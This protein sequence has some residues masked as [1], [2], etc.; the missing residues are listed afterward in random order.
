[1]SALRA[2]TRNTSGSKEFVETLLS[3]RGTIEAL[4]SLSLL[5]RGDA[6]RKVLRH[7]PT[8]LDQL[9]LAVTTNDFHL[10]HELARSGINVDSDIAEDLPPIYAAILLGRL[11]MIVALVREGAEVNRETRNG[12]TPLILAALVED[13][14]AIKLLLQLGARPEAKN[15]FGQTAF[16]VA[17][18][19]AGEEIAAFLKRTILKSI[20]AVPNC[21]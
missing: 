18:E 21:R 7:E 16:H 9:A 12:C 4:V 19:Y 2:H 8:N 1:M 15:R 20:T 13:L 6:A 10:L 17:Q 3:Y 5:M 14:D 11:N